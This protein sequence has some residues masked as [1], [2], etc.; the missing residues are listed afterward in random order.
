MKEELEERKGRMREKERGKRGKG[1]RTDLANTL[2]G[3]GEERSKGNR[4]GR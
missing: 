3:R 2:K 1:E 4:K